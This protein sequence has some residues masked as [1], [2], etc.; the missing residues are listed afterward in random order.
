MRHA[1]ATICGTN[2]ASLVLIFL[3][4]LLIKGLLVIDKS[5]FNLVRLAGCL[6]ID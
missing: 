5:T 6:Y 4:A 1:F 3:S 2:L